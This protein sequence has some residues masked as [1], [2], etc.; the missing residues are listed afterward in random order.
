MQG[1]CSAITNAGKPCKGTPIHG[2]Q[3][4]MSHHPDLQHEQTKIRRAGGEARSNARR[5]AKAWAALG[6]ELGNDDLPS[7]MKS[8]MFAVRSGKMTPG[9]ANA[10]ATLAR[11]SVQIS[12]DLELVSR[13]EELE[14]AAG[15]VDTSR[16]IRRIS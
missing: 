7:I 4:C 3:W 9:E 5:A 11:T 2:S 13:I 14:K 15:M 10:I 6:K 1:K 8:C 16:N 12:G